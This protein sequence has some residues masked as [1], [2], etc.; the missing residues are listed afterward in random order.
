[1]SFL[2]GT[3]TAENPDYPEPVRAVRKEK[4][5]LETADPPSA[6][7]KN[8]GFR[9]LVRGFGRAFVNRRTFMM[10]VQIIDLMTR[11]VQIVMCMLDGF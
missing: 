5:M 2:E 9:K 3:C 7:Q 4:V 1:M 10:A 6:E 8:V 11:I